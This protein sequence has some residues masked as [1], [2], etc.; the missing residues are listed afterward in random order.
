MEA[1]LY[2]P[3]FGTLWKDSDTYRDYPE[4]LKQED[5]AASF[6]EIHAAILKER[7]P[8]EAERGLMTGYYNLDSIYEK[9]KSLFVDVEI[10]DGKLWVVATLDAVEP[11]TVKEVETLKE[12]L[13]DLYSE[14]YC[15][16]F[17]Q[18]PVRI[19]EGEAYISLSG[20]GFFID[21][22]AEF[23]LRFGFDYLEPSPAEPPLT[24]AQ[25]ALFEPG[26]HDEDIDCVDTSTYMDMLLN[27]VNSNFTD[28]IDTLRDVDDIPDYSAEIA[29]MAEAHYY[30]TQRHNF[31]F[32]E[33]DYLLKFE[34]PLVVVTEAFDANRDEEHSDIMWKIFH[35]Q[36][37]LN[38]DRYKLVSYDPA[39]ETPAPEITGEDSLKQELFERLDKNMS[40][41]RD[42]MMGAS[43]ED[44]FDMAEDI[45]VRYAAR[46]YMKT[47]YDYN[48]GEVAFLLQFQNPLSLVAESTSTWPA[49]LDGLLDMSDVMNGIF[50]AGGSYGHYAKVM[51]AANPAA[52]EKTRTA[53]D[54]EKPSVLERIREAARMPKEPR[55]DTSTRKKQGPEL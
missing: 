8:D 25:M 11:L 38:N 1:K 13:N 24:P 27:R 12:Y 34:N 40:D 28:Y 55:K 23:A 21:T 5:A 37:A 14:D 20:D 41:Y 3:V 44:I 49:A 17:A 43:K 54:A 9:V 10:H 36:D 29:T 45:A 16:G 51:D 19:G 42:N 39:G 30:I 48:T 32:S 18:H 26:V 33:L 35:E 53:A 4:S 50:E 22:Q 6:D 15:E 2:S 31:H 46:E 47:A 52:N 7:L